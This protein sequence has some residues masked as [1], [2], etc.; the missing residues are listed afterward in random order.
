[1]IA[2]AIQNEKDFNVFGDGSSVRDYIE[3]DDV[4]DAIEAAIEAVWCQDFPIAINIG[5]GQGTTLLELI[6]KLEVGLGKPAKIV[7]KPANA[8]ELHAIVADIATAQR[9][10]NWRPCVD[11]ETGIARLTDWFNAQ[12]SGLG[13]QH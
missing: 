11:M 9:V 6:A 13:T 2:A 4:L 12:H 1:M 8:G 5:S 10:L 3:I 7:R